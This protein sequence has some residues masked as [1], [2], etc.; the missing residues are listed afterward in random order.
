[1]LPW[2]N[3][4]FKGS[5]FSNTK[6]LHT[7]KCL[8]V[9]PSEMLETWICLLPCMTYDWILY[10][11]GSVGLSVRLQKTHFHTK[12]SLSYFF[13]FKF[14]NLCKFILISNS[15]ARIGHIRPFLFHLLIPYTR[16]YRNNNQTTN[17]LLIIYLASVWSRV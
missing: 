7:S 13:L 5:F 1:M 2:Y 12:V 4:K 16:S 14:I 11:I 15:F 6:L 10:Y 17:P 9:C 8:F 3:Q